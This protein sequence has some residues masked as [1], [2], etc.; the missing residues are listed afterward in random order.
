MHLNITRLREE[1]IR[2]GLKQR[3]LAEKVGVSDVSMSRYCNGHRMPRGH[4]L[5]KIACALM[6]TPEY[7]TG[8]EG[9]EHPDLAY[10]QTRLNI[11]TYADRWTRELKTELINEILKTM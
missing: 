2:M 5:V 1:M 4:I 9:M 6:T 10:A 3:D 11:R 7:L 8:V